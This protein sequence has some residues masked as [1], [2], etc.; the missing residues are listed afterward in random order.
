[1][2]YRAH[3]MVCA[4]TG[5]VSNRSYRIK[6]SLEQEIKKRGL[7]KEVLVVATGCNG[8]CANGP[9]LVVW[10]EGIFYQNLS[11]EDVPYLVE[12]HLL[13]G[14]PV[15]RL[16][17][18]PPVEK[19]PIP[20]MQDIGFFGKQVLF[21][22]R[23]RG[24]ID[25]EKIEDYIARDG[26]TALAKVLFSMEPEEVIDVV[27]KS[28]L[29]GRGGG[30]F[31]TGIKWETC[32]KAAGE[33]R[34]VICNA[35]EGDPGAF[36][37]RS[38]IESDPHSVLE[39]M[40]IGAYAIGSHEG[41]VYIRKEYPLALERLHKAIDQARDYGLLGND[42][43]GS[44]FS[45]DIEIHRGGGAFV[46]GESTALMASLEGRVG[47]PRAK[48]IHTVENGL[49]DKP[50]N[51]NNV[52]TWANVPL[53]I[54]QGW[55]AF[56][57]VGT[58]KTG[59]VDPWGGS[60]GTK[61][62]SLVGKINNTGLIE[63]PMGI[64]LREI[65]FDIGGGIPGGRRFKA[66]Q[67][68]G[69]SGGCLPERLLDLQVDFDRLNEVGSMMGSGGMIVMDENS[70][71]VDVARYFVDFLKGESCGK[72]VP[73]REGL[74]TM[75]EILTRITKGEGREGDV[76]LL[77][78][79]SRVMVDSALCALGTSAP[80]PV[81]STI[82][83]FPEEYE[84]HIKDKVCPAAVCRNLT[85]CPCRH[86]C[87]LDID[88]PGYVGYI[89]R[90]E[91]DKAA[92][93]IRE[94]LPFPGICGR[95][96]H[97]PC[98]IKCRTGETGDPVAIRSLKRFAADYEVAKHIKPAF[99]KGSPKSEKV[100]VVGAGPAGLT[101]AY[102]LALEGYP[103]TVFESLPVAGGMLAIGI[104]DYRLPKKILNQEIEAIKAAG[105]EVR[106]GVTVGKDITFADLTKQGYK[107]LFI[108]SGAH[109]PMKL[110]IPGGEAKGVISPMALL[111]PVNLGEK[112]KVGERVAVIGGG[113]TAM[114]C[115][116]TAFR[117]GAKE[118]TIVYRRTR[119]EMPAQADEIEA[120]LAEEIKIEYLAAP[121]K[122][123]AKDGKV[124]GLEC[125]RMRLEGFD[126]TGRKRPVPIPGSEFTLPVET[127]IPA[128]S[129]E[130]DL[131]F[132]PA[133]DGFQVT[134]VATLVVDPETLQT[135]HV[136]VFAGGDVVAGPGTVM[137]AIAMGKLAARSIG[138]FLRGE[139]M[140]KERAPK[141]W[142]QVPAV[143]LSEEEIEKMKRPAMPVLSPDKRRGNFEE[144]DLGFPTEMAVIEAKRC[145]RCDLVR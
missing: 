124:V 119:A 60:T 95:V 89:A 56:A 113:N 97:H 11:V 3:L 6:D 2:P 50:S 4:G 58:R 120:A 51:L 94:E 1:M 114:D 34:Y 65:I 130:S 143:V 96:C 31:P 71:M 17:F 23:N 118:V 136:G 144:V 90:G 49:W 40:T 115:A 81:L 62:F 18:T 139:T 38:L 59:D 76:E 74:R 44:G 133:G 140:S 101:A 87:L 57:K 117:V 131:S 107:A 32:R 28:G 92:A 73:C 125:R 64:T 99:K 63:V 5:C 128:V 106:A 110:G 86:A 54:N 61:I 14:R 78:E 19:T 12:E 47:E 8:F 52:E 77:E 100:A 42:I 84:A 22:L 126:S 141:T 116:R 69:P 46:C 109:K 72:C 68:G 33:P 111:R 15:P 85:P 127:I 142:S 103:V 20:K 43:L 82:K 104:P 112:V 37:D 67:T 135:S 80:N 27:K 66:V 122:V 36:M 30:G 88:V 123:L 35:D 91:F 9:I 53:I 7:D 45:F 108:A 24:I 39:G 83:Y 145:L 21:A 132:L 29:R 134:K 93:I 138:H 25:P 70:C 79:I 102:Y 121:T 55:E 137:E 26:Y 129:W 41:Y 13:K 75:S 10:P 105:V 16:M 98:E 48:Y